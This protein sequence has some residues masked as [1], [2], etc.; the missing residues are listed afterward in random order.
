M[1]SDNECEFCNKIFSS[2]TGLLIHYTI[3]DKN[4]DK[5]H[6]KPRTTKNVGGCLVIDDF[7]P[8]ET[9]IHSKL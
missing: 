1:T 4:R 5:S 8:F 7:K 6:E 9:L 2:K 3:M